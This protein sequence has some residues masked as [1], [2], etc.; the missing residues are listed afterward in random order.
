MGASKLRIMELVEKYHSL[1]DY[2]AYNKCDDKYQ[3]AN[4]CIRCCSDPYYKETKI[5]YTCPQK[6]KL[7]VVRYAPAYIREIESALK[8]PAVILK[9]QY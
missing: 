8:K 5:D 6:R 1:I 7:Y 2:D 9:M 3:G 4:N